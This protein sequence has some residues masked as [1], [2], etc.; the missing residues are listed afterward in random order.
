MTAPASN[1]LLRRAGARRRGLT[2]LELLVA[3]LI[4]IVFLGAVVGTYVAL[5]N[6]AEDSQSRA[7][8]YAK[9]RIALDT[10]AEDLAN[11]I[12]EPGPNQFFLIVDDPSP[13]PYGD[14]ID[15]T[16]DGLVDP[17]IV[18]GQDDTGLWTPALDNHAQVGGCFER[19]LFVGVPDLG[20]FGVD[21]DFRFSRDE[22]AFR[23]PVDPLNPMGPFREVRYRV[24]TFEGLDHVLLRKESAIPPG[25]EDPQISPVA[26]D[27]VSF[28]VL[29]WNP[30][31]DS[32]PPPPYAVGEVPYWATSWDASAI[33][34]SGVEPI[35]LAGASLPG[36]PPFRLPASV[37]IRITVNAEPQE[38][39]DISWWPPAIPGEGRGLA[40]VSLS[41]T[42][43][44]LDKYDMA[45]IPPFGTAES[46][47]D[48]LIR[49]V[50]D[51]SN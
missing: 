19:R 32:T 9:A 11:L 5:G 50:E 45:V 20:D 15:N 42:V 1:G 8:A 2:L 41:T 38:L 51:C 25:P 21:D 47:Y 33:P 30:N 36:I 10:I 35:D 34:G 44:L 27:V 3:M 13:A 23:I 22:L 29:G 18:N 39:A 12:R 28:D 31:T 14:N 16:G 7:R 24:G 43:G 49:T 46:R 40:T 17:Q 48:L 37:Y 26:F 4:A 6:A